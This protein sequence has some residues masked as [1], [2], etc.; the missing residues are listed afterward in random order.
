M[1][2]VLQAISSLLAVALLLAGC[3]V[4]EQDGSPRS[5]RGDQ[6]VGHIH[7]LGVDPA[8]D[9]LYVATHHGLFRV[10]E[11][12]EPR[13]V[14]D[15]WQ[16]TMAFSVVGPRHFLASGHPDVREDLP[17]HLGLIESTDAGETWRPLALQG[18]A[19]F[20]ILEPVGDDLYAYDAT[21]GRLLVTQDRKSFEEV[22]QLPLLSI[23]AHPDD[24]NTLL[25]TT[26]QSQLV[27]IDAGTG[28]AKQLPGPTLVLLDATP[29]SEIVGIDP[30][31]TIHVSGD[32]GNTWQR[33]G[34]I[35]DQPAALMITDA[36]WYA[37]TQDQIFRSEDDGRTWTKVV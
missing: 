28:T 16:D 1:I 24:P 8:D 9:T 17:A 6:S 27:E 32:S 23:T 13:R 36:E 29:D 18:E 3:A 15:R 22:G 11:S 34:G 25:G 33:R 21:S 37:A 35:G 4:G 14:A 5:D 19:D 12:G 10:D 31:G 2:P 26:N 7:G 30:A 20:H